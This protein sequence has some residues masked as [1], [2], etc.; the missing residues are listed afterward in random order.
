MMPD[1][2][3]KGIWDSPSLAWARGPRICE[4]KKRDMELVLA[5]NNVAR[6]AFNGDGRVELF[7]IHYVFADGAIVGRTAMGLKYRT[8][9]LRNDVVLEVDETQGLFDW[10]SVIVH[11][12]VVM[13]R[14]RGGEMERAAYDHAV[15]VFRTLIPS[16]FTVRDP[17]PRRSFLFLVA[18][19]SITGRLSTTR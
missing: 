19:Q 12:T 11:G 5:R 18:P 2:R 8:W 10:R 7:P 1:V 4:M 17:T 14:S 13:L 15:S 3:T 6:I 16:A 9:L